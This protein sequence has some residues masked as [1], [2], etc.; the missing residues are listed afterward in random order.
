MAPE[1][2]VKK[3]RQAAARSMNSR[4]VVLPARLWTGSACM[5]EATYVAKLPLRCGTE[6]DHGVGG[7]LH[8]F[9]GFGK[10]LR[11]PAFGIAI[12]RAGADPDHGAGNAQRVQPLPARGPCGLYALQTNGSVRRQMLDQAGAAQKFEVIEALVAGNVAGLRHGNGASEQQSA[13]VA[14]V[15]DSLRNS[16]QP[17]HQSRIEGI[18][19]EN[20]AV[21]TILAEPGG[22][23]A[24]CAQSLLR[25]IEDNPVDGGL[26]RIQIRHPGTRHQRR[27]P[28][29]GTP[30]G[31]CGSPAATSRHRPPSLWRAPDYLRHRR[32]VEGHCSQDNSGARIAASLGMRYK[33]TFRKRFGADG[34]PA[35]DPRSLVTPEDGVIEDEEMVEIIEPAGLGVAED[36]NEGSGSQESNDN[37][38][39]AFGIGDVGLRYRGR[40]GKRVYRRAGGEPR[41]ARLRRS[42]RRVADDVSSYSKSSPP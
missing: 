1:S 15:S 27:F 33:V 5:E 6:K 39:L 32:G 17:G 9:G 12:R 31:V 25:R 16:G 38:F 34:E 35:D 14:M 20:G 26:A 21:E 22:E 37:G 41:G 4:R 7:G 24:A 18:L 11:Q 30:G 28:P 23:L 19:Q 13:A 8:P 3:I 10:P 29:A 2:F 36:L 40:P 42:S